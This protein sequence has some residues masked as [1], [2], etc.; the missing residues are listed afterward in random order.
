MGRL[1][2]K[3]AG[4]ILTLIQ[5]FE[6][7]RLPILLTLKDKVHDGQTLSDRDVEFLDRVIDDA[8]RTMPLTKGHPE[9]H[10]FCAC[11]I[12]LYKEIT[13]KALENEEC[14]P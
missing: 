2:K 12:H 8:K 4:V 10:E 1:S 11:V 14:K 5:R 13:E 7:Q 9:L 3:D 6:R